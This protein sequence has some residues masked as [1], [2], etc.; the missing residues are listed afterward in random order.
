MSERLLKEFEQ[1]FDDLP[2]AV[3][4]ELSF[5]MVTLADETFVASESEFAFESAARRLF[6]AQTPIGRLGNLIHAVS[7][8]DV[9]FAMDARKRFGS[10]RSTSQMSL[11]N[12]KTSSM[13]NH[14]ANQIDAINETRRRWREL[15]RTRLTSEAIADAL[16]P[17]KPARRRRN[18]AVSPARRENGQGKL[19]HDA[20][21]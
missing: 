15:R 4:G 20:I 7:I 8:F 21:S 14:Y 3:R 18:G 11:K 5:M 13:V 9:Y 10:T 6:S 12:A 1:F 17:P 19:N 16:T 2:A